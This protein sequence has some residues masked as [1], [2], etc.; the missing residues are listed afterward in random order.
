M[1]VTKTIKGKPVTKGKPALVPVPV[2]V[3]QNPSTPPL[4]VKIDSPQVM[5]VE[6]IGGI[7]QDPQ[8]S[9]KPDTTLQDDIT[10]AGQREINL[11]W[12][13]TQSMIAKSV[14]IFTMGVNGAMTI[15]LIIV[16]SDV[17]AGQLIG[18]SFLNMICGIVISFYFS[19][20]NHQ[21]I[22]GIGR[23]PTDTQKY[24]GR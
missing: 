9:L 7:P 15:V 24:V 11:L 3:V 20:T 12:E 16:R 13:K 4:S 5:P 10:T 22:G 14:V 1:A 17:T 8:A 23:K 6:I 21:A 19:R 18:I 2:D